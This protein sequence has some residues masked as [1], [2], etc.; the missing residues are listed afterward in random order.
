MPTIGQMMLL[1]D[2]AV[3]AAALRA[4]SRQGKCLSKWAEQV[5]QEAVHH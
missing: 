3:Y 4:S 5:L 2:P 1:A